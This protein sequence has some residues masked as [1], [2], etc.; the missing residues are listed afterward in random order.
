MPRFDNLPQIAANAVDA[1]VQR[2]IRNVSLP[3]AKKK[4]EE[5]LNKIGST[6][7]AAQFAKI[8][9]GEPLESVTTDIPD[10]PPIGTSENNTSSFRVT[11]TSSFG[12]QMVFAVMPDITER[13]GASYDA[14]Q[15]LHHPGEIL[16][17]RSSTARTWGLSAK[18]I[19]RN[20]E[21]ASAN[22]KYVNLIRSWRMP[23]TGVGTGVDSRTSRYL[24]A[25]PPI[26][27]FSAYGA[28]MIGPVPTVLEDYSWSWPTDV[29]Y[30]HAL[31]EGE[32]SVV[33][34]PVLMNI[35]L[36]L[37][38]SLSP[39]EYS[40]FDINEYKRG[41]MPKAFLAVSANKR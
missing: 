13:G 28:Q 33:P 12:D 31:G 7:T 15:V 40:G 29:D 26:L 16:K 2:T 27:T 1:V 41:N 35:Q 3:S 6:G 18:L 10:T 19:S 8:S 14:V 30:I 21:E 23:F 11:L 38:E 9:R 37:K 34:F 32:T 4:T 25:P 36:S 17:Y 5:A 24:G 22:L 20:L 39:A